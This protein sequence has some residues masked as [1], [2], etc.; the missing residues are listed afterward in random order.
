MGRTFITVFCF[1]LIAV[2]VQGAILR[3]FL[4]SFLVPNLALIAIV[5]LG[6]REVHVVGALLAFLLGIQF[7][8]FSATLLGPWAGAF[9]VVFALLASL[10]QRMFIES[11]VTIVVA[12]LISSLIANGVYV[13][14]LY[15]FRPVEPA[16]VSVSFAE[17]L[18]T[19]LISPVVFKFFCYFCETKAT[20]S[21]S[22]RRVQ[23]APML[24]TRS[25]A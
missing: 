20:S 14:L 7:D 15:Q 3:P 18:V 17:A 1:G 22:S 25:K 5:Y 4:P 2:L 16:L 19:A 9:M 11:S 21:R 23:G 13:T 8:L 24:S 12:S 10:S 6:L